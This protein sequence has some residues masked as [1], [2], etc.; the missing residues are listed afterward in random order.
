MITE[1]RMAEILS[2]WAKFTKLPSG[3]LRAKGAFDSS[4]LATEETFLTL[5][6]AIPIVDHE[7]NTGK[8]EMREG[9]GAQSGRQVLTLLLLCKVTLSC[10]EKTIYAENFAHYSVFQ[11]K[12]RTFFFSDFAWFSLSL[13]LVKKQLRRK[14]EHCF[15]RHFKKLFMLFCM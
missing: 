11:N 8:R 2:K 6:P 7:R 9:A 12:A 4:T 3:L 15:V 5:A 10:L 13:L 1:G 14:C